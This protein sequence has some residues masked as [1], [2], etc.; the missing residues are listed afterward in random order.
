MKTYREDQME[1]VKSKLGTFYSTD[2]ANGSPDHSTAAVACTWLIDYNDAHSV[3]L[4]WL[5]EMKNLQ[6]TDNCCA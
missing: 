6:L 1:P 3:K 4:S 5:S 2:Q